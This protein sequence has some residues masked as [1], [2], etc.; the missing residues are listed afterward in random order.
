[1]YSRTVRPLEKRGVNRAMLSR[2][3]ATHALGIPC[4]LRV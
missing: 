1:M 3:R 2:I 4:S